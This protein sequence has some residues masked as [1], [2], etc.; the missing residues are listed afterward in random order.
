MYCANDFDSILDS[1]PAG[2]VV[3]DPGTVGTAWGRST[4]N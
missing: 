2:I 3:T 4:D 1:V